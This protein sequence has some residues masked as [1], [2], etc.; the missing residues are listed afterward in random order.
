VAL[1]QAGEVGADDGRRRRHGHEAVAGAPG[2]KM[3]PVRLVGAQGGGRGGLAR[4]IL[5]RGE[6]G[7][8]GR[9]QCR[10]ALNAEILARCFS[11]LF[12]SKLETRTVANLRQGLGLL[13]ES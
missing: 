1:G 5:R 9:G 10:A 2:G 11:K 7:L 8:A 12:T 4:Q 6:R 3:R 13:H